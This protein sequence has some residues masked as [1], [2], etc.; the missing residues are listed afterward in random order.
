MNFVRVLEWYWYAVS[1]VLA[2]II[3]LNAILTVP[4]KPGAPTGMKGWTAAMLSMCAA[5]IVIAEAAYSRQIAVRRW[6]GVFLGV[7]ALLGF[8]QSSGIG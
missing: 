2:V 4:K 7:I 3:F 5:A 6:P 1:A 8:V